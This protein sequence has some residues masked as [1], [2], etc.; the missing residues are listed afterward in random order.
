MNSAQ[1]NHPWIKE[2][3]KNESKDFLEF[4]ENEDTMY[5]N[6]KVG[7]EQ[8]WSKERYILI[9]GAILGLARTLTLE[10]FPGIHKYDPS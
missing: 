8:T 9:K 5:L 1:L 6:V 4:N 2:E 3:I 10:K 7:K